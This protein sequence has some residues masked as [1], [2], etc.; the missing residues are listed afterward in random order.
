MSASPTD[1][2]VWGPS[3]APPAG[4]DPGRKRVLLHL[5]LKITPLIEKNLISF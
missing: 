2:R 5:E 3:L 4:S 1:Y